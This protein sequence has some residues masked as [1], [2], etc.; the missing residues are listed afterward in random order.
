MKEEVLEGQEKV[1]GVNHPQTE[2]TKSIV[3]KYKMEISEA[4]E[5]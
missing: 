4:A 5:I 3:F 2:Q 1:L